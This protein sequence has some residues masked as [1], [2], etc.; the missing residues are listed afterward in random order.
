MAE[1]RERAPREAPG[2]EAW[3]QRANNANFAILS[4]YS[5]L[6]PAFERLFEREGRDWVKFHA[7]VERL[8]PLSR[9][10]RRATLRAQGGPVDDPDPAPRQT[11]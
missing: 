9:E 8:V 5:D 11:R 4:A 6:V 7:A 2:Y 1:L 3:F 10:E